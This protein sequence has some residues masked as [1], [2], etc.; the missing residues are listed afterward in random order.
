MFYDL[1]VLPGPAPGVVDH[2]LSKYFHNTAYLKL[3]LDRLCHEQSDARVLHHECMHARLSKL[4]AS[5]QK[6]FSFSWRFVTRASVSD[7]VFLLS[8]QFF[9]FISTKSKL[10]P[11]CK[12]MFLS[13]APQEFK[14]IYACVH[15]HVHS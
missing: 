3:Q 2:L 15:G 5:S 8:N 4:S 11:D 7:V 9:T 6:Y 10:P 13:S 14:K 12:N 1:S